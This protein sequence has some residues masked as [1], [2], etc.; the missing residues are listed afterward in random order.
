MSQ[1]DVTISKKTFMAV[2]Y[3]LRRLRGQ[4]FRNIV[5]SS[6][7]WVYY[8]V[9]GRESSSDTYVVKSDVLWCFVRKD[10]YQTKPKGL[11]IMRV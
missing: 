10:L 3:L 4:K 1:E 7:L 9:G 6:V 11:V 8:M 2:H 5:Y